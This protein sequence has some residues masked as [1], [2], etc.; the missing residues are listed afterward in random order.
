MIDV[1]GKVEWYV[2]LMNLLCVELSVD[3]M[4]LIV[5]FD[6]E[7]SLFYEVVFVVMFG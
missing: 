7:V 6:F 4:G 3:G 1:E 2:V 5:C